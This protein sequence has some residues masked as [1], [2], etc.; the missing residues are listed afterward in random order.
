MLLSIV[1]PTRN[2]PD[3]LARC[4][5]SLAAERPAVPYAE[6]I[7]VDDASGP[8]ASA[9]N[10][11]R[12]E[13]NGVRFVYLDKR[14]GA[15]RAR[16]A[17]V[18]SAS[19]E[20]IAFLDDDVRPERGWSRALLAAIAGAGTDVVGIEGM[21]IAEGDG[22]WDHEVSNPYGGLYLTCNTAYRAEALRSAGGFDEHFDAP[23]PSCEDHEL[24]ARILRCG[25]IAFEAGYAVT[26]S[27][28]R[29]SFFRY[30]VRSPERIASELAAEY[31]FHS[32]Q[33]D[34]Y[35]LFRRH[36]TFFGTYLAILV[37]HTWTNLHR[38]AFPS[39]ARHPLQCTVLIA[40]GAIEQAVAWI[41]L[42]LFIKRHFVNQTDFFGALLDI[43]RTAGFWGFADVKPARLDRVGYSPFRSLFFPLVKRPVHSAVPVVRR[44]ARAAAVPRCFLRVDDV[45]IDDKESV[46]GL[47]EF[48]DRKKIPFLAAVAGR[49]ITDRRFAGELEAVA[50]SGVEIGLHGFA[51]EGRFGP[52][53]SEILQMTCPRLSELS[54]EAL[55]VFTEQSRPFV[56]VPPF[57]AVSRDQILHLGKH[58]KVVC[59]GPETARFTDRMFGPVALK[60][61]PWYFPSFHPFYQRARGILSSRAFLKYGTLG[62][63]ICYTVHLADEAENGFKDLSAL[64]DRIGGLLASWR[65][66]LE[67]DDTRR[68]NGEARHGR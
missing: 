44:A 41:L 46:E 21:V 11:A 31:Y 3:L 19:G 30:L 32:K 43:R 5:A 14:G 12:S 8:A 29:I 62:C 6:I 24:A 28:R 1:I 50:R 58:F 20:W 60:N 15:A 33:R 7:V 57:N 34:R 25:K 23:S 2:R 54:E 4:L 47:C 63:N 42:P 52:F 45:F 67:P 22:L 51:H 59:G 26:H 39:L 37:K 56:F 9:G 53:A 35:H 65:V 17:G 10:K 49:H 61:G 48:A 64:V 40:S 55:S 13:E 38:R 66:F 18:A 68:P 36:R 27:A 16:N